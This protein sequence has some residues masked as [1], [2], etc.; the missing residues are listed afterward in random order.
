M[1][2]N[3]TTSIPPSTPKKGKLRRL[4]IAV[5]ALLGLTAS[6]ILSIGMIPFAPDIPP[7]GLTNGNPGS[8]GLRRAFPAMNQRANNPG[9]PEKVELGRLLYFDPVLSGDNTQSCATCHHPD[10]GFSDGRITS[11]GV[12]GKGVGPERAGGTS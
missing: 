7:A 12:N 5:I 2:P 4:L 10:L 11:M 3:S 1:H 8:G 9:T 6:A